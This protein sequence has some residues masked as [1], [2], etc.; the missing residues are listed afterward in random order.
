MFEMDV[1]MMKDMNLIE[2]IGI[3]VQHIKTLQECLNARKP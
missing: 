3:G 1:S 2:G